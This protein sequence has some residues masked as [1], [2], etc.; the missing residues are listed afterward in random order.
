MSAGWPPAETSAHSE[1]RHATRYADGGAAAGRARAQFGHC[2]RARAGQVDLTVCFD[3]KLVTNEI[4]TINR[5]MTDILRLG[6]WPIA[7]RPAI[8]QNPEFENWI[9]SIRKPAP[10]FG[11]SLPKR[12]FPDRKPSIRPRARSPRRAPEMESPVLKNCVLPLMIVLLGAW[13]PHRLSSFRRIELMPW[14]PAAGRS[15]VGR[16]NILR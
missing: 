10:E 1:K 13:A 12:F 14:A 8:R 11:R 4:Q 3:G 2:R 16:S 6:E 5:F 15:L 9:P 7:L